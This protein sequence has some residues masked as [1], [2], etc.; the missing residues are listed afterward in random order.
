MQEM[1]NDEKAVTAVSATDITRL[2]WSD[3]V[4]AN[5]E[6]IPRI[7]NAIGLF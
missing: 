3:D 1:K 2:T 5:A 4:T 6:Q 7:C